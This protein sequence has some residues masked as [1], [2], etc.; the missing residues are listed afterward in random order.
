MSALPLAVM[1][2][3]LF[4]PSDMAPAE[5][6]RLSR[7]LAKI[8]P[9][10]FARRA[11]IRGDHLDDAIVVSTEKATLKPGPARGAFIWDGHVQ[12]SVQ[13]A[14]GQTRWEVSHQLTYTGARREITEVRYE[15]A[16]RIVKI[17]PTTVSHWT[18]YCPLFEM[19]G[20]CSQFTRVIFEIPEDDVRALA[21]AYQPGSRKPW[22]IRLK[23][24]SG[25]D[26]TIG[27]AP[28]EVAGAWQ[29][30]QQLALTN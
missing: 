11:V 17:K 19:P 15:I 27:V 6:L 5:S 25:Q 22:L 8:E 14:S 1:A 16:G 30:R 13:R 7:G 3:F 18:D 2:A 24:A 29:A 28:A 10:H 4:T 23:E 20:E 9:S 12:A 21:E 26:V